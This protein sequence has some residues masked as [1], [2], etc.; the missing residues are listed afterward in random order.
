VGT[1]DIIGPPTTSVVLAWDP[2]LDI[3][4]IR[5][6][7][8]GTVL[9]EF[10]GDAAVAGKTVF[11]GASSIDVVHVDGEN[12]Y[13]ITGVHTLTIATPLGTRDLRITGNVL[14]W[15][16]GGLTYRMET[17]LSLDRAI[18]IAGSMP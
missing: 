6:L 17:A 11:A 5:D 1:A 16:R 3:P 14:I 10:R 9:M 12:A 4:A 7:A 18:A 2:R 13:W 8:W 15:Q